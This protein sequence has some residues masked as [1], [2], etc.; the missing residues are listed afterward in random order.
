[1][2]SAMGSAMK[3]RV[4]IEYDLPFEDPTLTPRRE[5]E[6]QR[7]I[8]SPTVLALPGSATVKVEL[9]DE[10]NRPSTGTICTQNRRPE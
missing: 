10:P 9:I 6:E 7:W 8:A 3:A 5:R 4:T 1:M 2:H